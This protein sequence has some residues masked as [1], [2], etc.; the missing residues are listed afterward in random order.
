MSK[1]WTKGM[2]QEKG[3]RRKRKGRIKREEEGTSQEK[4]KREDGEKE[5]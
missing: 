1:E 2:S 4:E 5:E 3:D